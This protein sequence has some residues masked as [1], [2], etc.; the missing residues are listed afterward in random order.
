VINCLACAGLLGLLSIVA[1]AQD[2][3]AGLQCEHLVRPLGI[4]NPHPRLSWQLDANGRAVRQTAYEIRVSPDSMKLIIGVG[5]NRIW[6]IKI[7]SPDQLIV[8]Q[9]KA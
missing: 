5:T 7:K 1:K 3:L 8:Y 9:G 4:D 2:S 6:Q